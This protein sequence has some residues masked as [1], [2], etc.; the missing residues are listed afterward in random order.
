MLIRK[1]YE[2]LKDGNLVEKK[3]A[4]LAY[5]KLCPRCGGLGG[6]QHYSHVAGGTCFRCNGSGAR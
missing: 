4:A 3:V 5:E 2:A 6:L 1:C